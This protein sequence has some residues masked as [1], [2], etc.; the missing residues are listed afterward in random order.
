MQAIVPY[1]NYAASPQGQQL[2]NAAAMTL[3]RVLTPERVNNFLSK[4]LK[5]K[6]NKTKRRQLTDA[7]ISGSSAAPV[8]Y[9]VRT[10][11]PAPRFRSTKGSYTICN[12]EYVTTVTGNTNFSLKSFIIQPGLSS[13]FPWLSA[14]ANTHQRYKFKS[15]KFVYVPVASTSERGRVTLA[16]TI[17]VKDEDPF[18]A[19]TLFQYP[20]SN[21]GSVWS[22]NEVVINLATRPDTLYT[23][24]GNVAESDI[25]TYDF[26][27]FYLATSLTADD[28][29][30]VGQLFVD[31]E[32]ELYTPKPASCAASSDVFASTNATHIFGDAI[33]QTTDLIGVDAY[34]VHKSAD[35]DYI[36]MQSPGT[37]FMTVRVTGDTFDGGI[38]LLPDSSSSS[39]V[40]SFTKATTS[41]ITLFRISVTSRSELKLSVPGS[42]LASTYVAISSGNHTTTTHSF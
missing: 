20:S 31:Y 37:Y 36:V 2:I 5:G 23:R 34:T 30:A 26:G 32:I 7:I 11:K 28:T 6:K 13:T 14:I 3:G 12:R 35:N 24:L 27:K 33:G 4:R 40:V 41:M 19:V 1:V 25:K 29:T 16:Y 8:A 38:V 39:E 18:D 42:N 17:D 15:L 22:S 9:N 21:E 10:R